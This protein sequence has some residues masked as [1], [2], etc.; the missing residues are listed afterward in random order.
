VRVAA[1]EDL[2]E[3]ADAFLAIGLV[4]AMALG[5]PLRVPGRVSS[6]LLGGTVRIQQI[7][8]L[9]FDQLRVIEVEAAG[10]AE[11]GP[12][13]ERVGAFFSGGVD[14]FYAALRYREQIDDLIFV[15]GFDIPLSGH[16]ALRRQ[17]SEM[18]R[19]VADALGKDL[20]EVEADIRP[21]SNRFVGWGKYHGSALA[22]IGLLMQPRYRT[23]LVPSSMSYDGLYQ[24]GSHPLVDPL[25]STESTEFRTVG[26]EARRS[27]RVELIAGSDLAMRW[28]R[29][30]LQNPNGAYNCGRCE[31]CLRTMINLRTAGAEGRCR[32]LPDR[33]DLREV[34]R[35]RLIGASSP[36]FAAENLERLESSGRD[37]EL[38][39]ALRAALRA[40]RRRESVRRVTPAW[41]TR[42]LR[43]ARLRLRARLPS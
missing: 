23:I 26:E 15:H 19:E 16:Q 22:A 38:L 43:T 39:R 8:R 33:I 14:S 20:V 29:V 5:V 28:L 1:S 13:G 40:D 12:R 36:V 3:G 9:W 17:A 6:R 37:P 41:A 4:P 24:W 30:C 42:A 25:W 31:K 7:F 34:R 11:R 18:A 35:M 10:R 2:G 32:T 21:F 27:E